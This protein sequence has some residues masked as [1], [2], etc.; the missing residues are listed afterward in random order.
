MAVLVLPSC[1]STPTVDT[2]TAS[3]HD[4]V[5]VKATEKPVGCNKTTRNTNA[6]PNSRKDAVAT[7]KLQL[8]ATIGKPIL[9]G[10][11]KSLDVK[12]IL[13]LDANRLVYAGR[14]GFV[15]CYDLL[16]KSSVWSRQMNGTS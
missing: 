15:G 7:L 16:K 1:R 12:F 2:K 9:G 5:S 8:V 4:K 13:W 10:Q 6:T 3:P 14:S 11:E